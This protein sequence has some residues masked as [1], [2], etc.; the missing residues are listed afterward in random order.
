MVKLSR[1]A[2]ER[3]SGTFLKAGTASRDK[4]REKGEG[5]GTGGRGKQFHHF[6]FYSLTTEANSLKEQKLILA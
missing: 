4:E 3:R 6:L 2:A 5:K 1:N